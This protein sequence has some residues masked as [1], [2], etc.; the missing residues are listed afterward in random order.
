MS[1][2][3]MLVR[4]KSSKEK[5]KEED[6]HNLKS[7]II[8]EEIFNFI[9]EKNLTKD[10]KILEEDSN[11]EIYISILDIEPLKKLLIKIKEIVK[12]KSKLIC[13]NELS[14]KEEDSILNELKQFLD[15]RGLCLEKIERYSDKNHI[16]IQIG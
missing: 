16:L 6:A 10:M 7:C 14:N 13:N 2:N 15:L 3:A 5:L 4:Y 11:D 8:P 12:N 9:E 1:I